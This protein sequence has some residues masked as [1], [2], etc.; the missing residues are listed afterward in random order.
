MK[1]QAIDIKDFLGLDQV[2]LDPQTQ[3]NIIAFA[4]KAG[5]SLWEP[6]TW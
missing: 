3:I 5:N 2:T 6:I 1:I 4:N